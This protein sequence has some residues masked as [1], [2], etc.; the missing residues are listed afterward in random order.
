M[1]VRSEQKRK[2]S[3]MTERGKDEGKG[4][5]KEEEGT[6]DSEEQ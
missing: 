2:E 4:V 3:E 6:P 1:E 5:G